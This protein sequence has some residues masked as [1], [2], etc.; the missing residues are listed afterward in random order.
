MGTESF[1]PAE[2]FISRFEQRI[3]ILLD[4]YEKA[5]Q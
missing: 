2:N 4:I 1:L 5:Y 3:N